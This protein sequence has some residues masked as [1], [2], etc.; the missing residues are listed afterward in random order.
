MAPN[1]YSGKIKN[2]NALLEY[3]KQDQELIKRF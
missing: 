2:K 1:I 3:E